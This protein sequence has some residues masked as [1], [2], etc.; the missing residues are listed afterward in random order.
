M[1][2]ARWPDAE[3][4]ESLRTTIMREGLEP[5]LESDRRPAR[6]PNTDR[7]KEA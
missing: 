5:E 4:N 6:D 7:A 2:P 3:L 1:R